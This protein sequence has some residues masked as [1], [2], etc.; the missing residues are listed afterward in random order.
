MVALWNCKDEGHFAEA[1]KF[2]Y[3]LSS[4]DMN[5]MASGQFGQ[6]HISFMCQWHWPLMA[7]E[8]QFTPSNP[9]IGLQLSLWS[10]STLSP[11]FSVNRGE[12]AAG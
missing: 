8:D 12:D 9:P 2:Y 7:A 3:T 11:E 5:M 4:I 1:F 6:C 10:F